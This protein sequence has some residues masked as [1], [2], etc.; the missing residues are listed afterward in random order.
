MFSKYPHVN[1]MCGLTPCYRAEHRLRVAL[2]RAVPRAAHFR[3]LAAKLAVLAAR[4]RNAVAACNKLL[5][6]QP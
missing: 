1:A 3:A 2:A 5:L 4:A 6:A